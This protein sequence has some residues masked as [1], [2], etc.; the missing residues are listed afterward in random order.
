LGTYS[1]QLGYTPNIAAG[2]VDVGFGDRNGLEHFPLDDVWPIPSFALTFAPKEGSGLAYGAAVYWPHDVNYGWDLFE[3]QL[4]Y[5]TDFRFN[6][7]NFRTDLDVMDIHPT[8]ARKFGEKLS[9]GVGVSITR[10]DIILRRVLSIPNTLDPALDDYPINNFYGDFRIDGNGVGIGANAGLLWRATDK[11]SIGLSA[12]SPVSVPLSGNAEINMAWPI[13][14]SLR[15]QEDDLI[16]DVRSYF[17]G[18]N[19]EVYSAPS[20]ARA[21]FEFDLDLPGQIG[22]GIGWNAS[23]RVTL[24]VDLAM[25]FWSAVDQWNIALPGAGL[26][27]GFDTLKSGDLIIPFAWEDQVRVSAGGE[28]IARD[29]LALR[30]GVYYDGGAAVDA[31][32]SPNFPDVGGRIG[33]ASGFAYEVG[34]RWEFSLAQEIAFASDR[35]VKSEGFGERDG[36]TVYPGTYSLTQFETLLSMSYRF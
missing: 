17:V 36:I 11:V 14:A 2:G 18:V 23:D 1:P 24:A 3:P 30:G 21:P 20:Y 33:I 34:G 31:T 22:A 19:N 7:E 26:S 28:F 13:N 35:E 32:F 9:V 27:V 15:E 10:G 8:V 5:E 12:Q 29:N 4:G 25:T 6:A 16:G